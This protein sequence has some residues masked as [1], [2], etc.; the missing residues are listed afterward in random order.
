[1]TWTDQL[2]ER[3]QKELAL[4]RTYARDFHHG[5][6]GH[7]RL[8]LIARLAELLDAAQQATAEDLYAVARQCGAEGIWAV[9]GA[10]EAALVYIDDPE[11]E[12][13]IQRGITPPHK[14]IILMSFPVGDG[15]EPGVE[16]R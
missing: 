6:D 2:D 4:A 16:F 1:M 3:Q 9:R 7:S 8:M 14:L 15:R 13:P 10:A 11:Q 12:K 5:T